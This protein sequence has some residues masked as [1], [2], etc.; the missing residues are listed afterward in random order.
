MGAW[1][2]GAGAK[3]PPPRRTKVKGKK[4]HKD[5]DPS[6]QMAAQI[7]DSTVLEGVQDSNLNI[8]H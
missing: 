1:G 2:M 3:T 8:K 6:G 7:G 5:M 4:N